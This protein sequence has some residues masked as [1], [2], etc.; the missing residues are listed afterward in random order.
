M[1]KINRI[2]LSDHFTYD[3]LFKFI[4]PSVVMML[5]ASVYSVV[6][7]L[8]IS[9]FAGKTA[10]SSVNFVMPILMILSTPGFMLGTGGTAIV[11]KTIGEGNKE[12]ANK[13]FSLFFIS[14]VIISAV[15]TIVAYFAIPPLTAL[16][17]AK[18]EM[19]QLSILYG[20]IVLIGN[21]PNTLHFF[22]D[23][24]IVTAEKPKLGLA[25]TL[26]SGVNNII[27]DAL[28]VGLFNWGIAGAAYATVI[29]QFI[30]GALPMLYFLSQN[31]SLLKLCRTSFDGKALKKACTN[32]SSELM[33]NI[34]MSLVGM[35]YNVQLLNYLG[36]DGVSAYGVRMY[37]DFIFSAIFIGYVIGVSPI[38]GF[39]FGAKNK[40]ELQNIF[41][42]S[43]VV[44]TVCGISMTAISLILAKPLSMLYVGKEIELFNITLRGFY[45]SSFAFLFCGFS[46]FGSC[47]FTALSDGV[48]SAIISFLRTL[49]FQVSA[50]IIL[51]KIFGSDGIWV[52]IVAAEV[53]ASFLCAV[54][55]FG[56]RKKYGYL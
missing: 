51:P 31:N 36:E 43:L 40:T 23:S 12:K 38:V 30:S 2:Q 50:V 28:F 34:S 35:L 54:F 33:S 5:F 41:K 18:G 20:R 15:L 22:F 49:V 25:V 26:A 10:F 4:W 6:D 46:I 39:N 53:M 14:T 44:L 19:H 7:G 42:K 45:L 32:G 13:L 27:L 9:R 16:M 52:S 55:I 56:K 1:N 37:L 48:T 21:I 3:R 17:G 29:S 8:F 24:F 47:F 11:S